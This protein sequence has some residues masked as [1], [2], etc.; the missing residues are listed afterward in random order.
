MFNNS[1]QKVLHLFSLIQFESST[2]KNLWAAFDEAL[3][4]LNEL[5]KMKK[6]AIAI[7]NTANGSY[8]I[9]SSSAEKHEERFSENFF[10]EESVNS[11][12]S[13]GREFLN[14]LKVIDLTKEEI[15]HPLV[16]QP[17]FFPI[18]H[19]TERLGVLCFIKP[20]DSEITSDTKKLITS[21]SVLFGNL[22]HTHKLEN[23]LKETIQELKQTNQQLDSFAAICAHDLRE[24]LRTISNYSQILGLEHIGSGEQQEVITKISHKCKSMDSLIHSILKYSKLGHRSILVESIDILSIVED[25]KKEFKASFDIIKML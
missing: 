19:G 23:Q 2:G 17:L 8:T 18:Y 11:I 4:T 12:T 21:I 10:I 13:S 14:V 24:P 25:L 22:I 9:K 20:D 7:Y 6:S 15:R 16:N 3:D 1:Y 5:I